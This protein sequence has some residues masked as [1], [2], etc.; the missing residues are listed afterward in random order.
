VGTAPGTHGSFG[1]SLAADLLLDLTYD[2][3][4]CVTQVQEHEL[5]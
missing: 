2:D 5:P 3:L 1:V 4:G